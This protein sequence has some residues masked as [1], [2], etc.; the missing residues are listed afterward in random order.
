MTQAEM[1]NAEHAQTPARTPARTA[2]PALPPGHA[3]SLK[4][5]GVMGYAALLL[6][7]GTVG[8]WAATASISGAVIAPGQF[9][10]E[11]NVKK[12][13]HPQG[14]VVGELR[15]REGDR[16]AENDLL[17]RLDETMPRANLLIITRQIDELSVRS[18]RLE[19]ERDQ[20]PVLGSNAWLEARLP[21]PEIV[22]LVENERRLFEARRTAREGIRAQLEKRIGQLRSEISGLGEQHAAK[23]REAQMITREL[24]GVR[25]L[26]RQNLVQIT[27]LSQL[28]REA[29]SLGGQQGQLTAQIAQAEGRIA[30]IELQIIQLTE[31][32][33]A[34]AMRDLRELQGRLAELNERR[35][36]AEDQ[37][38]RVDIRAPVAG[39]V[40]QLAVHTVGGVIT[41]AEPAML[42]VPSQ[43]SLLLEARVAP[44]EIDQ[45]AI[46]QG[47]VVKLHAFNQRT[48][49]E[50]RATVTRIAADVTREP[51]TGLV[52]YVV[53]LLIPREELDRI[54]PLQVVP[55]MQADVFIETYSRSPWA[56]LAK[57]VRDQF[58]RAFRER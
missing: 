7:A 56:Y 11:T 19:A 20:S 23:V 12:V 57:P 32:L 50:L 29:A 8:L 13:Q 43:D 41:P 55:G 40:H 6:F 18:L 45:L 9:V 37:L 52:F 51:Q 30:E 10:S 39:F 14:G 21:A 44:A 42:I 36:A 47:A 35:V 26:F 27:R 31:D 4:R 34:E 54:A 16:V 49:P 33:R 48:T 25:D 53:R 2:A 28:E 24:T 38:R 1:K 22:Q 5:A 15:V 46:G 58:Q 3:A 17:I